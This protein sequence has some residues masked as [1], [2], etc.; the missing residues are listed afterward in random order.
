MWQIMQLLFF[1]ILEFLSTLLALKQVQQMYKIVWIAFSLKIEPD[2]TTA[3]LVGMIHTRTTHIHVFELRI[4]FAPRKL[5][6]YCETWSFFS[7]C[8]VEH[9]TAKRTLDEVWWWSDGCT[10]TIIKREGKIYS[11]RIIWHVAWM[12]WILMKNFSLKLQF[13]AL[14]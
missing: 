11:V 10:Y 12:V 1:R 9:V 5:F 3:I 7:Y 14:Q 8:K 6:K 4:Q 2:Y 13:L